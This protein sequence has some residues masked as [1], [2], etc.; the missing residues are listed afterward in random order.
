[1]AYP[2]G[3]TVFRAIRPPPDRSQPDFPR[4]LFL[5]PFVI[6]AVAG[7][8]LRTSADARTWSVLGTGLVVLLVLSVVGPLQGRNTA[9][10]H[11]AARRVI[12][13]ALLATMVLFAL[14]CAWIAA[15]GLDG[16]LDVW[17]GIIFVP[18]WLLFALLIPLWTDS[19]V[20]RTR[21]PETGWKSIGGYKLVYSNASDHALWVYLEPQTLRDYWSGLYT[22]NLGHSWGRAVMTTFAVLIIAMLALLVAASRPHGLLP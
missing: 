8:A 18:A 5:L 19:P 16:A 3:P 7:F 17:P 13:R 14:C 11:D 2:H 1:M 21:E 22:P 9:E 12:L 10:R 20:V 4:F 15:A 6:L